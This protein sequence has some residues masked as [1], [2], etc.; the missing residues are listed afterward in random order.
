MGGSSKNSCVTILVFFV[1]IIVLIIAAG[2]Y[3]ILISAIIG[4][5]AAIVISFRNNKNTNSKNTQPEIQTFNVTKK[6]PMKVASS[7]PSIESIYNDLQHENNF[8]KIEN[9]KYQNELLHELSEAYQNN[10]PTQENLQLLTKIFSYSKKFY[11]SKA[12]DRMSLFDFIIVKAIENDENYRQVKKYNNKFI[13]S[14]AIV[15]LIKKLKLGLPINKIISEF[16][17]I[18][19]VSIPNTIEDYK[20]DQ[21]HEVIQKLTYKVEI[22]DFSQSSTSKINTTIV[23]SSN[24]EN[25]VITQEEQIIK[26]LEFSSEYD[27][28]IIDVNTQI[29]DLSVE[30]QVEVPYWSHIYVYSHTELN[31]ATKE[32]KAFYQF[33]RKNFLNGVNIDIQGNTNYAFILFYDLLNEYKRHQDIVLL[34]DQLKRLGEICPRTK[35]Y[36]L[37]QLN[38]ILN[39][40]DDEYSKNRH[41]ELQNPVYQFENGFSEY[42]P[43]LY[44]LGNQYKDKLGLSKQ[45][46]AW[47]NKFYN[48]S[49][50][51]TSIEGCCI[52]VIRQYLLIINELNKKIKAK[53]ST[54]TKEVS[55]LNAEYKRIYKEGS[56][57]LGYNTEWMNYGNSYVDH[58]AEI[59]IYLTIFKRVENSVRESFGHKRKLSTEFTLLNNKYLQDEFDER[60][61]KLV[62]DLIIKNENKIF[63]PDV[64]TQ[65]VLNAQNVN[66]WK[67]AFSK[68]TENFS[69][70][71]LITFNDTIDKLEVTNEKNPNIEKLFFEAAKF[72][73]GYDK[74]QSL[75][76]Y[77]KNIYYDLMSKKF[78]YQQPTIT[79]KKV[80]FSSEEQQNE[81]KKIIDELIKTKN[82][83]AAI[84]KIPQIYVLK[85]KK[86][87]LDKNAIN[88]IELKHVGT[89]ELLNG[90][91]ENEDN[92]SLEKSN[93]DEVEISFNNTSKPKSKYSADLK[94][95][96]IQE[97][98]V[99]MIVKNSYSIHQKEVEQ[100]ALKHGLFKNQLIDSINEI[101]S[102]HLDGEALIE[103]DGERYVIEQS[104]YMEIVQ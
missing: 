26:N 90:Y 84:D 92:S 42:N 32:Q 73:A 11:E 40:R 9:N 5:V 41:D 49:N 101:C 74:V 12:F 70:E 62:N 6:N 28:S 81:Y 50:A 4:I 38:N 8:K 100:Y 54:L 64:P 44:K 72:I 47:L 71:D 10:A 87:I 22:A 1:L 48:P 13:E 99:E 7:I 56:V 65:I 83:T 102:T 97:L 93:Q 76:Y 75:I 25:Q 36:S 104:Y 18:S 53:E 35:S 51:F 85:R 31:Y 91:L 58:Q 52:S 103:E 16:N 86:I 46:I 37:S 3:V 19:A 98:L 34:E 17:A 60:V 61:G 80:L 96:E 69:K 23:N 63:E 89:V 88:D 39:L 94:L 14:E 21:E 27:Q 45:E 2:P 29:L 79:V 57:A 59:E 20:V 55:F 66:R 43:D 67:I 24:I 82:I 15:F 30:K 33:L 78:D 77:A 95:S 68:V